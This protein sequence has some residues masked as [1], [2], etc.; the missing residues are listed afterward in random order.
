VFNMDEVQKKN[1]PLREIE[2]SLRDLIRDVLEEKYGPEWLNNIQ[3]GL[4]ADWISRLK[5][6]Q[7][8]DQGRRGPLAVE[9]DLISYSD[10]MDL[11]KIIENNKTIFKNI[12]A[13]WD[14]LITHLKR[15]EDLR[16]PD[17]HHR[18]LERYEIS[19]L[20][21]IAGEIRNEINIWKLGVRLSVKKTGLYFDRGVSIN[22]RSSKEIMQE[23]E[24]MGKEWISI[25]NNYFLDSGIKQEKIKIQSVDHN[26][27]IGERIKASGLELYWYTNPKPER[28][29]R[30]PDGIDI[31]SVFTYIWY[32][33]GSKIPLEPLLDKLGVPYKQM[34]YVLD[35]EVDIQR[36][37]D[38]ASELAGLYPNSS[39][40]MND[41]LVNVEF[42]LSRNL[43]VAVNR[44]SSHM[45]GSDISIVYDEEG[46][47]FRR[48]HL[49]LPHSTL[50]AFITG[51][52]S[53]RNIMSL[54]KQ[55]MWIGAQ[56]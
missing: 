25:T 2:K 12:F 31:K 13:D 54:V 40:T 23:A 21:G 17:K 32:S 29:K 28:N 48:A 6:R 35:G 52:V 14:R 37:A 33:S 1:E 30:T 38:I 50:F 39:G 5:E 47:G 45:D 11:R 36:L 7:K 24:V 4:G 26:L 19:L 55:A 22:N 42:R 53:P 10:F 34:L 3:V 27:G 18:T 43:R 51:Y 44:R 16:N 20:E 8:D 49:L 15:A 41:N 56:G 9:F 46:K